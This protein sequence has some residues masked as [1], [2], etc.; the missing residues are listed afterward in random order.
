M[1]ATLKNQEIVA[2]QQIEEISPQAPEITQLPFETLQLIGGG[3]G[4]I[5]EH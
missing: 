3:E 4:I 2:T 1:N 5:N